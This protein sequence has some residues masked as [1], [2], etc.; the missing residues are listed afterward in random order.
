MC[1]FPEVTYANYLGGPS[2]PRTP[3]SPIALSQVF[4][5]RS[6][7]NEKMALSLLV[8][9]GGSWIPELLF[10]RLSQEQRRWT[11]SGEVRVIISNDAGIQTKYLNVLSSKVE[12]ER[13]IAELGPCIETQERNDS[14]QEIYYTV[15]SPLKEEWAQVIKHDQELA[16]SALQLVCFSFPRERLWE[17]R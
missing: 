3:C 4:S 1:I 9:L 5:W 17:P 6:T 16:I 10:R 2:V 14:S 8:S 13:L 11:K 7:P 15:R 12:F